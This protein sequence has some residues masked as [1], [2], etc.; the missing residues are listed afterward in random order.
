MQGVASI[1]SS[2]RRIRQGNE[3]AAL[4]ALHE[5]RRL[6]R[7]DLAR[8]LRLNRSSS[9]HIIAGLIEEGLVREVG[10]SA[11]DGRGRRRAGRP[12]ILLELVPE[13]VLFVGV[14]IGVEHIGVVELDL[15]A[16][17]VRSVQ[18]PF[19]GPATPVEAAVSR[20]LGLA[21]DAMPPDRR[22]LCEGL[23]LA[24]P[25]QMGRTGVVR[26]APLLGWAD[27]DLAEVVRRAMPLSVPV[28]VENDA[29]ALAIGATYGRKVAR[30]G[31]TLVLNMESGVGGGILIEGR[32]F[33]GAHGLAGEI[34]HLGLDRAVRV[35]E[36][37]GLER[38]LADY[39]VR[40]GLA[41]PR[42]ADLLRGVRDREGGAVEVAEGWARTLAFALVQ[43]CRVIDADEI[44]LGGSVAA[45]Y[46]LVADRVRTHLREQQEPSFPL[47]A[48]S[49]H[50]DADFGA[51]FG[52]ACMLHQR[53]LSWESNRFAAAPSPER[54]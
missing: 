31:V 40:R 26:L 49:V 39:G 46:P 28:M 35:E 51:A 17:A 16:R 37:I 18:E 8:E 19:D 48:I 52:A 13:A 24:T 50:E 4:R 29:N 44:V 11:G 34:G 9:G 5:F 23:G 1:A 7:A 33:R 27:V 12:G 36:R 42:L 3:I 21:F 38:I 22:R 41:Q 14:E 32:L 20:A 2:P 6:S 47:P 54:A 10:E 43:A 53:F 30:A 15:G 25:S 45:L